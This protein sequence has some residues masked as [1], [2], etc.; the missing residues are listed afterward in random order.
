MNQKDNKHEIRKKKTT[1]KMNSLELRVVDD[2]NNYYNL[3]FLSF[4]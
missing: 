1:R 4:L 2:I 3:G